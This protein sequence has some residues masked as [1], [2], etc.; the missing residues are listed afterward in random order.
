LFIVRRRRLLCGAFRFGL[1]KRDIMASSSEPPSSKGMHKQDADA[2]EVRLIHCCCFFSTR[3]DEDIH[4]VSKRMELDKGIYN[5]RY[6]IY[7]AYYSLCIRMTGTLCDFFNAFSS[8]FVRSLTFRPLKISTILAPPPRPRRG[9]FFTITTT[10]TIKT[11]YRR[12]HHHQI[13]ISY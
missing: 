13:I 9:R 11:R 6:T 7:Q 2:D 8:P 1:K 4:H 3:T 5:F 10:T 12:R